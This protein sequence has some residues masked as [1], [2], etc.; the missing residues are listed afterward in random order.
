[1]VPCPGDGNIDLVV[2]EKDLEDWRLY[3]E[4]T[5]LSSWY[6]LNLDG[7]TNEADRAIIVQHLGTDCRVR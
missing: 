2:D 3:A 1:N 4:S 7:L 5:G 6:D